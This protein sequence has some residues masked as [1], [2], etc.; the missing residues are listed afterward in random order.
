[1]FRAD[2]IVPEAQSLFAAELNDIPNTIRKIAF[3]DGSSPFI[4]PQSSSC[5]WKS[6]IEKG[7]G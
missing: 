7:E 4:C 2:V 3:H 6:E 1:M 5:G